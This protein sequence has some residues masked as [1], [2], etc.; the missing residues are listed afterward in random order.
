M[1]ARRSRACHV[2]APS[3]RPGGRA[4]EPTEAGMGRREGDPPARG[5][6]RRFKEVV[7]LSS[8]WILFGED[9][10]RGGTVR[11]ESRS[12]A[13]EFADCRFYVPPSGANALALQA[14]AAETGSG[15]PAR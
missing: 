4:I 5:Q 1:L 12:V 7:S 15:E 3:G 11:R 8:R 13:V 14:A 2:T 10:R 9:A 6:L